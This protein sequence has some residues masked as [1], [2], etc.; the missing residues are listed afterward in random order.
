[1]ARGW[2]TAATLEPARREFIEH[3]YDGASINRIIDAAPVSRATFYKHFDSKLQVFFHAVADVLVDFATAR[4]PDDPTVPFWESVR[5]EIAAGHRYGR[6]HRQEVR[7]VHEGIRI[8]AEHPGLA[9]AD[10]IVAAVRSRVRERI[11]HGVALGKVRDD[12]DAEIAVDL[13]IATVQTLDRRHIAADEPAR[14]PDEAADVALDVLRRIL[15][16]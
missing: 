5:Q 8:A 6:E 2:S 14:D 12:L 9:T 4:P 3:G 1:M 15:T 13:V 11:E 7:L 10:A 16:P